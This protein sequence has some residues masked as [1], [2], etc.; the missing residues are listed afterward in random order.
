MSTALAEAPVRSSAADLEQ[1]VQ[2]LGR[3]LT[4]IAYGLAWC[5][6]EDIEE[7]DDHTVYDENELIKELRERGLILDHIA[8][9]DVDIRSLIAD[10]IIQVAEIRDYF[11]DHDLDLQFTISVQGDL[12]GVEAADCIGGPNISV[13][14]DEVYGVWGSDRAHYPLD[15][16]TRSAIYDWGEEMFHLYRTTWK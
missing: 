9:E 4:N 5:F 3:R 16:R 10:E 6:T 7:N 11:Y 13:T 1:S 2:S 14:D 12:R 15:Q 8:D